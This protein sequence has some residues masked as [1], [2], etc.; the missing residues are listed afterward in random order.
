M[1]MLYIF[2]G[3]VRTL[4]EWADALLSKK[5]NGWSVH[6][7][8][9]LYSTRAPAVLK[10]AQRRQQTLLYFRLLQLQGWIK[11]C[12]PS[13]TSDMQRS[14]WEMER[15]QIWTLSLKLKKKSC[16]YFFLL[17]GSLIVANVNIKSIWTEQFS[18]QGSDDIGRIG[19]NVIE[20]ITD[21]VNL[22]TW[23]SCTNSSK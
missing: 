19:R 9:P 21:C 4:L 6:T 3:K 8:Y 1:P 16:S 2:L 10:T 22:W 5:W 11:K 7:V 13:K 15:L 17:G 12:T 20:A 23:P 14:L 18:H